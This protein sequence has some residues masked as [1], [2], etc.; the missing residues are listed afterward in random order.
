[1]SK[2]HLKKAN[3][4]KFTN[5]FA[6]ST[7]KTTTKHSSQL[8]ALSDQTVKKTLFCVFWSSCRVIHRYTIL[9]WTELH[10]ISPHK[11]WNNFYELVQ[12]KIWQSHQN[13]KIRITDAW[14]K[15]IVS[16]WILTSCQ[17]QSL[18]DDQTLSELAWQMMKCLWNICLTN[19]EMSM[20][21]NTSDRKE[22]EK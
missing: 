10:T 11:S 12:G 2:C 20:K 14:A 8:S 19:D 21:Y 4:W 3:W 16:N 5:C 15:E 13:T 22:R 6:L 1:M 7:L 18:L 9:N 17:P